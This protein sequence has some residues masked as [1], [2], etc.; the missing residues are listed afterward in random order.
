MNAQE[1]WSLYSSQNNIDAEYDAWSFGDDADT[2]AQLVMDGVKTATASVYPLYE[3][4]EELPKPGEYSVILNSNG[5][6]VCI[7][8]TETVFVTPFDQVDEKQAWK[9]G[10]GNRRLSY[11]REVHE[12]FFRGE[13]ENCGLVF[14][15]KIP[16]VCEE[17][18]RVYP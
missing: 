5:E 9:E 2:L 8:R 11:W 4:D 17:F 16:I 13:M 1:M 10:E 3:L 6:A 15:E 12:R 18:V 7:I 14:D